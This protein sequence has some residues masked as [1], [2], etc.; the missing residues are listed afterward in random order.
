MVLK[1][2]DFVKE[3]RETHPAHFIASLTK[4]EGDFITKHSLSVSKIVSDSVQ[5]LMEYEEKKAIEL[6]DGANGKV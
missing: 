2:N 5:K 4:K 1:I 3:K 6:G